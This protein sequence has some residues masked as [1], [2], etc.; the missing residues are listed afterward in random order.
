MNS[1]NN[2]ANTTNTTNTTNNRTN[3]NHTMKEINIYLS[4]LPCVGKSTLTNALTGTNLS[5]SHTDQEHVFIVDPNHNGNTIHR[6]DKHKIIYTTKPNKQKMF[7]ENLKITIHDTIGNTKK[8]NSIKKH[9]TIKFFNSNALYDCDILLTIIDVNADHDTMTKNLEQ[10]K[11]TAE[12]IPNNLN[13]FLHICAVNKCDDLIY[14]DDQNGLFVMGPDNNAKFKKIKNVL[15]Q[16]GCDIVIPIKAIDLMLFSSGANECFP[17]DDQNY[18]RKKYEIDSQNGKFIDNLLKRYGLYRISNLINNFVNEKYDHINNKR[19]LANLIDSSEDL[20]LNHMTELLKKLVANGDENICDI[21]KFVSEYVKEN[22]KNLIPKELKSEEDIKELQKSFE[23]LEKV[24]K[25]KTQA[26]LNSLDS[27]SVVISNFKKKMYYDKLEM[28]WSENAIKELYEMQ[29]LD[30]AL[31]CCICQKHMNESNVQNIVSN[32]MHS[33]KNNPYYLHD[34]LYVFLSLHE[35]Y[36]LP[37]TAMT[38]KINTEFEL[39]RMR[40]IQSF[41][42]NYNE[43]LNS[44]NYLMYEQISKTFDKIIDNITKEYNQKEHICSDSADELAIASATGSTDS[45][46]STFDQK[47]SVMN[48]VDSISTESDETN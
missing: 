47:K 17:D 31:F 15:N 21:I 23:E 18:Y 8:L 35:K 3:Q 25:E 34:V 10:I 37:L 1:T 27:V 44:V 45:A 48:S 19:V 6:N 40:L 16:N 36:I 11:F 41:N 22:I 4:G 39:I 28:E 14:N 32:V 46:G 20:S 42:C 30:T 2:T 33:T 9:Q 13:S 12:K 7:L 24:F 26:S 29:Y 38:T 5:K 43:S